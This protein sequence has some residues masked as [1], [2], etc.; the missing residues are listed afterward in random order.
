[1]TDIDETP[2]AEEHVSLWEDFL[3]IFYEPRQVFARRSAGHW[4]LVLLL[5]TVVMGILFYA[6]QGVLSSIFDAEF[7]R[8]MR[9]NP[10]I[11]PDQ[12]AKARQMAGVFGIVGF[13]VS[14]PIGVM[15]AGL[16]LWGVGKLFDSVAT[17][18]VAIMIAAYAQFPRVLQSVLG[19][20]QGLLMDTSKFRGMYSISFSPARFMDPDTTSPILL[21]FAGRVDIFVIWSTVLLAIGLQVLGRVPRTQAYIAAAVVWLLGILPALAGALGGGG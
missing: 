20:V 10:A 13:V 9:R 5:L 11:T 18:S 12:M 16:V 19:L 7:A 4:G 17:A 6:S 3:D 21:A 15:L 1:M 2:A 14:F 8:A